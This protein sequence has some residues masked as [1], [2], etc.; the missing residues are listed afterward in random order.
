MKVQPTRV[1]GHVAYPS[2]TDVVQRRRFLATLV[3]AGAWAGASLAADKKPVGPTLEE[4][5]GLV[6]MLTPKLNHKDFTVRR[7][8]TRKLITVGKAGKEKAD[9]KHPV[10]RYVLAEMEKLK[11][12]DEPEVSER[13]RRVILAL[14]PP[15]P[16]RPPPIHHLKGDI[17]LPGW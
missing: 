7:D 5:R 1:A 3:S 8:A 13:A 15:P 17:A 12:H 4:A 2:L 11:T 10:T 9:L 16:P 14:K 6:A